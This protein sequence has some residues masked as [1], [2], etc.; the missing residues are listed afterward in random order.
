MFTYRNN[1]NAVFR[2]KV[3]CCRLQVYVIR[4]VIQLK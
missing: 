2:P 3:M 1:D 4:N